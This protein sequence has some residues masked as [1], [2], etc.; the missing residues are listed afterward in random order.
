MHR[1]LSRARVSGPCTALIQTRKERNKLASL[2]DER[3]FRTSAAAGSVA[4][5]SIAPPP[6]VVAL[7]CTVSTVMVYRC[8]ILADSGNRNFSFWHLIYFATCP[9]KRGVRSSSDT[10]TNS[11]KIKAFTCQALTI[12]SIYWW[13]NLVASI[14]HVFRG[15]ITIMIVIISKR[16]RAHRVARLA[17]ACAFLTYLQI[18]ELWIVIYLFIVQC[19]RL[20]MLLSPS[21]WPLTNTVRILASLQSSPMQ[22]SHKIS[23]HQIFSRMIFSSTMLTQ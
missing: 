5:T 15:I 19:N 11:Q 16:G 9:A 1:W 23:V 7:F 22:M 4:W 10:L 8:V 14:R 21:G 2:D 12:S 6:R 3:I 13:Q 18:T 17:S 20:T